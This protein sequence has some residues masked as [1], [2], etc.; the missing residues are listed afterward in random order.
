[1]ENIENLSA[2]SLQFKYELNSNKGAKSTRFCET[3]HGNARFVF[4]DKRERRKENSQ[5]LPTKKHN[6]GS[7]QLTERASE[8]LNELCYFIICN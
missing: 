2:N 8:R 1:M 4:P 3:I 6:A 7:R 5:S